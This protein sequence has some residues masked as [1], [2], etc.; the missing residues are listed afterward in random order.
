MATATSLT[1][2]RILALAAGWE[3]VESDLSDTNLLV[4]QLQQA[5]AGNQEALALFQSETLPQLQAALAANDAS[6]NH[7]QST[8][9]V[10]L[11]AT[12]DDNVSA[13]STLI[14]STIPTLDEQLNSNSGWILD[15]NEN[16][17]PAMETRLQEAETLVQAAAQTVLESP[18]AYSNVPQ[19]LNPD[20]EGRP[21]VVGDSWYDQSDNNKQ[22]VWNGVEWTTL[23]V[24]IP[25]F[26]LTV[27]KFMSTSHLI[28]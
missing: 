2:E 8:T 4:G 19:P 5:M 18:R 20:S 22:Y 13:I 11:Q 16:L 6:V 9:L 15:L 1:H 24:D 23:D 25:D 28:Y 17:L 27:R 14:E 12:L 26:S 21:L 3:G 7:L 10:D